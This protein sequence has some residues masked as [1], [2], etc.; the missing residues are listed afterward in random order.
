MS[1]NVT[2]SIYSNERLTIPMADVQHIEQ[3]FHACDLVSGVKKGDLSGAM[4]IT[5]HT[6]WD[7]DIDDWMNPVWLSASEVESF[8]QAWCQYRHELEKDTLKSTP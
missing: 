4:V 5:K 1:G 6:T 2:E 7:N 3:R 8:M